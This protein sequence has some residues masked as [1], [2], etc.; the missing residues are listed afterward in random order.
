MEVSVKNNY[1]K[2]NK[3]VL[4]GVS[5]NDIFWVSEQAINEEGKISV[6]LKKAKGNVGHFILINKNAE[7]E[8]ELISYIKPITTK[9]LDVNL[10]AKNSSQRSKVELKAKAEELSTGS[11][12]LAAVNNPWVLPELNNPGVEILSLPNDILFSPIFEHP[13]FLEAISDS[14]LFG[15]YLKYYV[16]DEFSWDKV[17]NTEGVLKY[18]K[19]SN[20]VYDNM[21]QYYHIIA[22]NSERRQDGNIIQSNLTASAE[23]TTRNPKYI[24]NLYKTKIERV[25]AYKALLENGTPLL[26]VI[27]TIKPFSLQGNKIVFYGGSNSLMAQDGALIVME[28]MQRGTDASVLQGISPFDVDRIN[29]STNPGDIQR[30]TGLNSVGLIEI[31]LKKGELTVVEPDIT[32]EDFQFK[33]PDY[34]NDSGEKT[35]Y[36]STLMWD[37]YNGEAGDPIFKYF[38]SDLISPVLLRL[39]YFPNEGIPGCYQR[40]YQVK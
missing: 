21:V 29:V 12:V 3:T 28:G 16:P 38:H 18:P 6:D 33:A 19:V 1:N 27:Q 31:W 39:Y 34:D 5:N 8:A 23:F 32:R 11:Y 14:E 40:T 9:N 15:Q 26:E 30:Y 36:R 4:I 25:P 37:A 20:L 7:I 13:M 22:R 24:S 17:L 35:D 2:A 10:S